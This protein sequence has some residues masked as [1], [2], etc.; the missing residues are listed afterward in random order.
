MFKRNDNE[1]SRE[2]PVVQPPSPAPSSAAA[3]A[4]STGGAAVIGPSIRISGDLEGDEDLVVQGQIEGTVTLRKNL[5]TVGKDGR[6]NATVHARA[7]QVDGH[8]EGDLH[9]EEQ[10]VVR[11]SGNVRGNIVSPR[12]T[13]EDGCR[14]KGS[15]DMETVTASEGRGKVADIKGSG[16]D[17]MK[18]S[19]GK[20]AG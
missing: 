1:T 6:V 4:P 14:F 15:I 17:A 9:G 10:V 20:S 13:L 2:D 19:L 11:K 12:V 3:R 16:P 18:G 5:L 7:V 8:V